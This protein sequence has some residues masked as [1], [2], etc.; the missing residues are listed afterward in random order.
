MHKK[1]SNNVPLV[2]KGIGDAPQAAGRRQGKLGH[3]NPRVHIARI[4]LSMRHR[5]HHKHGR[6]GVRQLAHKV[7]EL[8]Q[9]GRLSA[10][11]HTAGA[12]WQVQGD[13]ALDYLRIDAR[14][15]Q[16]PSSEEGT[17]A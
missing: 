14:T 7:F 4:Y 12:S 16:E 1:Q 11:G 3:R 9:V 2:L 6:S 10:E 15:P 5:S 13:W 17:F 8:D